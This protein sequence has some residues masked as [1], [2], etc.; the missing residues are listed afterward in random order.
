MPSKLSQFWQE[1]KRRRVVHVITV[2]ASAAFVIIELI[3]NLAEPL[4][5]PANLQLVAVII[6]ATGFPLAIIL[7]WIF[8]M[9]SK[10]VLRTKPLDKDSEIKEQKV[11]NA[12]KV[13]T[14]ISF[15]IIT[16]LVLLNIIGLNNRAIAGSVKSLV[17]LP[18]GNYTGDDDME[19]FVSG[20]HSSL[21]GDMGQLSSLRVL[22]ETS[23]NAYKDADKAL[24]QIARELNVDAALETTVMCL[25]DSICLQV[26]LVSGFHEEKQLWVGN[27][28]EQKGEILNLYNR[29]TR[30]IADEVKIK[31]KPRDREMLVEVRHRPAALLESVY[32]GKFYMSLLTREGFELG[33]KFYNDAI[34]I[35]PSDPLPYLG[36]ALGYNNAGHV[37]GLAVE[38]D[39]LAVEYALKALSLDS[40]L[41]EAHVV[42]ASKALYREWDFTKGEQ[43]LRLALEMNQNNAEAHYHYG[44]FWMLSDQ[45]E[46]AVSE[47]EIAVEIDPVNLLYIANLAGLYMWKGHWDKAIEYA[48]MA[49]ELN[50]VYPLSLYVLGASYAGK[51]MFRE[52]IEAHEKGVAINPSFKHGLGTVYALSGEKERA[53]TIAEELELIQAPWYSWGIAEIYAALGEMDKAIYWIEEAY[54]KRQDFVPWFKNYIFYEPLK[55]DARFNEIVNSLDYPQGKF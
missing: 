21:I 28:K 3:S 10:G 42:I 14:I 33:L 37:S 15:M 39:R 13:A 23:A 24:T 30:Q 52:A 35:D 55:K 20:M 53:L 46:K 41:S 7:S 38:A 16:G 43:Y 11:P 54:E 32:K 51:G 12:W 34:E 6:L 25:D 4:N 29:I 45:L 8:D 49:L 27:F 31:L 2:Y 18:F 48:N 9:T 5:L 26:K 36:L 40:S 50:S 22:G 17:I 19:Y 44:W 1:L 47:L